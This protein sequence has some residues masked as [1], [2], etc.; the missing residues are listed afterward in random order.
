MPWQELGI[1]LQFCCTALQ[2]SD[3]SKDHRAIICKTGCL[4]EE[5]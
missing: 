3:I 1:D 2:D 4:G 5:F